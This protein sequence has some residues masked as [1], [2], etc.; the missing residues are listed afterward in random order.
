MYYYKSRKDDSV[1]INKLTELAN[2]H[3]TRGFDHYFGRIRNDGLQWNHKRVKR[4]YDLLKLNRRRKHKRRLPARVKEP[5]TVKESVNQTWSMDFMSDSLMSG[6][7]V[8]LFNVMD[9]YNREMLVIEVGTSMCS[10]RVVRTLEQ[11]IDWRGKPDEIRVDNGPEFRSYCFVDFCKRNG[12]RLH[13]IQPGKPVQNAYIE[14]MNRT[15]R[16]DILD[17]YLFEDLSQLKILTEKWMEDYNNNYPHQSLN[18]LSP[19]N[20][21]LKNCTKPE[22]SRN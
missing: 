3:P 16:E 21:A 9:D 8:R 11:I 6:R 13:Y 19:K 22:F 20:Y 10:D 7:K 17:A 12:I 4:V 5:L 2:L 15:I 14:R 1:V 18:G